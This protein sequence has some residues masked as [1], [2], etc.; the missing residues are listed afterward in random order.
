MSLYI[1]D[2]SKGDTVSFMWAEKDI[3]GAMC[4]RTV[5]GS[6][7]IYKHDPNNQT[8]EQAQS[9]FQVKDQDIEGG[10]Y[11]CSIK[12][13]DD[14]YEESRDYFVCLTG[15][16]MN[17]QK[18][19]QPL[20]HFSINNRSAV[21][22]EAVMEKCSAAISQVSLDSLLNKSVSSLDTVLKEDTIMAR[23]INAIS[24]IK[25]ISDKAKQS[26]DKIE[27]KLP[28][29]QYLTGTN[30]STGIADDSE[31]SIIKM[32]LMDV[33]SER[34][35]DKVVTLIE[36]LAKNSYMDELATFNKETQELRLNVP[37]LKHLLR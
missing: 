11:T 2:F 16:V 25:A 19:N 22:K 9:I 23:V 17:G 26:I 24:D 13:S 15:A 8:F 21:N 36:G 10:I 5:R 20:A 6:Y 32:Q 4:T 7:I 33:F 1:G 35:L 18:I 3:N 12:L 30:K 28:R 34:G 14:W 29:K 37:G 31:I 27:E